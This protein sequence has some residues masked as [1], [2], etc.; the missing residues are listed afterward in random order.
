MLKCLVHLL[1][2]ER[3]LYHF[4]IYFFCTTFQT[5]FIDVWQFKLETN[6]ARKCADFV[7]MFIEFRS[8]DAEIG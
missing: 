3:L 8:E 7:L 6:Y 4:F 5:L 2:D 1:K